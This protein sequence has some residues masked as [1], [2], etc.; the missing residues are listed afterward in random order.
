MVVRVKAANQLG[1]CHFRKLG[2]QKQ[3]LQ[4]IPTSQ[5]HPFV[6][7]RNTL[8]SCYNS[9][10]AVF[11]SSTVC[12]PSWWAVSCCPRLWVY[13]TN[14]LLPLSSVQCQI[15]GFRTSHTTWYRRESLPHW[16]EGK[17]SDPTWQKLCRMIRWILCQS[18]LSVSCSWNRASYGLELGT[19]LLT[20]FVLILQLLLYLAKLIT[21]PFFSLPRTKTGWVLSARIQ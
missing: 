12:G 9:L 19:S 8:S 7:T 20:N 17:E 5:P 18:G 2:R 3:C 14:I 10:S 6:G 11:L 16:L 13:M 4:I 15:P 1:R 21:I